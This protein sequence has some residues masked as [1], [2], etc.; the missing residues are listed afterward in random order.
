M[1]SPINPGRFTYDNYDGVGNPQIIGDAR[2]GFG[3]TLS[4]D[5]LDRLVGVVGPAGTTAYAYDAHG[6]RTGA[7]YQYQPGTLRLSN[8]GGVAF[9]YDNNGNTWTIGAATFTYTPQNQVETAALPGVSAT[10]AY[11]SDDQRVKKA[12]GT[13]TTYFIRGANG[14]LLT[15]WKDPGTASGRIRDYMYLGTR[16]LSAVARNSADDPAG[17]NTPSTK[18]HRYATSWQVP[19]GSGGNANI[20]SGTSSAARKS[21]HPHMSPTG[22]RLGVLSSALSIDLL[23]TG[24]VLPSVTENPKQGGVFL[25]FEVERYPF[26]ADAEWLGID[27]GGIGSS[28]TDALRLYITS[29]GQ[30][31][32]KH[33]GGRAVPIGIWTS[34][35]VGLRTPH[36][37][38]LRFEFNANEGPYPGQNPPWEG[39]TSWAQVIYD[40]QSVASYGGS[41]GGTW[42]S[43]EQNPTALDHWNGTGHL[44]HASLKSPGAANGLLMSIWRTGVVAEKFDTQNLDSYGTTWRTTLIEAAAPGM[45]SEW[46]GGQPDWRARSMIAGDGGFYQPVISTIGNQKISYRMES[47]LARGI[48]GNISSVMVGVRMQYVTPTTRVFVRRNG[49]ETILNDLVPAATL[50]KWYRIANAGWS[51]TDIVE[52]GVRTGENGNNYLNSV[53]LI[54][55]HNTP[56]PAPLTDTSARV[57]TFNY[58][59][60]G[61]AQTIDFGLDQLPTVLIVVPIGGTPGMEPIWWW[62][63]RQG[64]AAMSHSVTSYGRV[65][66][67][68]GKFHVVH[69]STDSPNANGISYVAIALFDPSGR[70]VIPFAVSKHSSDDN[71][72]HYLRYPQS[73]ELASDFTPTFVFGG[74]AFATMADSVRASL[75]RGPGHAGDL[76][77][78]LGVTDAS[79]ADRIQALGAGTVQFGTTVEARRGDFAFWAGRVSD[80]VSPTRLMA[81]TSYVGNGLAS[82][83]IALTLNGS[84]PVMALVV[85]T[86]ATAKIYRVTGD[87]TGRDTVAGNAAANS[88]TA[89]SANQITVGSALNATGV[90][91]DVWTITT[92]LVTP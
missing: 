62:D 86:N 34:S 27:G 51:P 21:M 79:D 9:T 24:P 16:L 41:P 49:V 58:A 38:E 65:W 37:L 61:T 30:L 67:Q 39:L 71:Y 68:K 52:V 6:N 36:T 55:E 20:L 54:V 83:D 1:G 70:F 44:V 60:N 91:Y 56:E 46:T 45:Y 35:P 89:M 87:T 33:D 82:R 10:Y 77:G 14:E 42:T 78:K 90:T 26:S 75:Y 3:Q 85:P 81:V 76:T 8:Q 32:L 92:G 72:T 63:S 53:A 23:S 48:T 74:A 47:L 17:H 31:V 2:Q 84:T 57:M 69:D 40:G 22:V 50:N 29:S 7:G 4:Y 88:I 59:G 19:G 80:G 11:D 64:A 73:G 5:P 15:E 28:S 43:N 25:E 18:S 66:P 12:V 13:S